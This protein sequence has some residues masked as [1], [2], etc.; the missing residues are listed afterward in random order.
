MDEIDS[1]YDCYYYDINS[2]Y[3]LL[4]LISLFITLIRERREGRGHPQGEHPRGDSSV[5][6]SKNGKRFPYFPALLCISYKLI[7][8][9]LILYIL[10]Q[11]CNHEIGVLPIF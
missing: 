6:S 2:E 10:L 11:K 3:I 1:I 7:S 5:L 8:T 4:S 9:L